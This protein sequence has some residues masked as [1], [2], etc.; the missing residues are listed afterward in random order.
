MAASFL[1]AFRIHKQ[2]IRICTHTRTHSHTHRTASKHVVG[3]KN[4]CFFIEMH[5]PYEAPEKP[6]RNQAET[7]R[8]QPPIQDPHL[9]FIYVYI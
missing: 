8:N 3:Y 1:P 2:H 9:H 4:M 5:F 6:P 7:K